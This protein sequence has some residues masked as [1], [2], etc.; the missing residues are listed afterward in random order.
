M[1]NCHPLW[2]DKKRDMTNQLITLIL[3]LILIMIGCSKDQGSENA[4]E[5]TVGERLFFSFEEGMDGWKAVGTDLDNPPV[6]WS[7]TRTQ[8]MA[9]DGK[10]SLMLN[11]DNMNDMGKIWIQK[12]ISVKPNCPYKVQVKYAFASA[13]YGDMNLWT[14][15]TGVSAEPPINNLI[16]QD[17][18]GAGS[19]MGSGFKWL[20]KSYSFDVISNPDGKLYVSIGVWGTWET[21]RT[22]YLDSIEITYREIQ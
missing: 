14:I 17:T 1:N 4:D 6:E 12:E 13:D 7:I 11:L 18:T 19:E 22:Y 21:K 2:S 20:S 16:Y 3:F 8:K 9:K 15:I 10:T 5:Q